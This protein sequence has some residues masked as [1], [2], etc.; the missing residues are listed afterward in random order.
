L[1]KLTNKIKF[2]FALLWFFSTS[3]AQ[4]LMYHEQNIGFNIGGVFTV[5]SHVQRLGMC[6]NFFYTN[7]CFQANSEMRFYFNL[8]D[9]GPKVRHPEIVFA[10]GVLFG[11]GPKEAMVNPFLSTVSNQT[12]Y[13]YSVGYS[14]NAW[15]NTVKTSQQTGVISLQFDKISF[16]TENDILARPLL[17]RFRTGAF[18]IQYQQDSIAQV[19]M[20]CTMWT[21]KMGHSVTD[22]P[23]YPQPGYMDTTGGRYTNISHGL[24]SLQVKY[25]FALSQIIQANIGI[26][27][28]Q[29]RNTVQ[30]RII[31][32]VC[33]LP[34]KW[35]KRYN[36]HIPMLDTN[37]SQYLYREGQKIKKARAYWGLGSNSN[38][39]Y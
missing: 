34:K 31:H 14:Y 27:A 3:N 18:L 12:G 4:E 2:I 23:N 35:F 16:I 26:D 17:D 36:C 22:D 33:W 7:D 28:E 32:D 9:L 19:A 6:F 8:K 15:F 11:Y 21:G 1:S 20:N 39:F 29:I 10:Q 24:L 5:G 25:H 38:L 37:G 13:K 30:N